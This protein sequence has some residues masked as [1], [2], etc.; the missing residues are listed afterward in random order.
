MALNKD[1][2]T[3]FLFPK[4]SNLPADHGKTVVCVLDSDTIKIDLHFETSPDNV[5]FN[6]DVSAIPRN[7]LIVC[8]LEKGDN[9]EEASFSLLVDSSQLYTI[10]FSIPSNSLYAL[11]LNH[12]LRSR[13]ASF[14]PLYYLRLSDAFSSNHAGCSVG[15]MDVMK[16][17]ELKLERNITQYMK[18]HQLT[19][20]VGNGQTINIVAFEI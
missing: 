5:R 6:L 11:T 4:I 12:F 10:C 13:R 17:E 16:S 20:V 14:G 2:T 1:G 7:W 9:S 19:D 18:I 8:T 3:V 15:Q